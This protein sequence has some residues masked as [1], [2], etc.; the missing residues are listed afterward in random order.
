M[1][2]RIIKFLIDSRLHRI[3]IVVFAI[4]CG[5][6]ITM[7]AT[8]R[9]ANQAPEYLASFDPS[10]GFKPAQA[11][12]TEIF[13]QIAGSLECYGSPVPYLRHTKADHTRVEAEYRARFG[14][15]PKS[16]CPAYMTDEYLDRFAANWNVLSA[17]LGLEPTVKDIGGLMRDAILRTRRTG[18]SIVEIF[19]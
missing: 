8:L 2:H 5:F 19:N 18:T 16:Y 14:T 1:F 3:S 17:K 6:S 11:D 15:V 9:A 12:L 4:A 7:A 13:L 10:T